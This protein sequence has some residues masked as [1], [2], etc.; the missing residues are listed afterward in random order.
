LLRTGGLV[1]PAEDRFQAGGSLAPNPLV[2][3]PGLVVSNPLAYH[4]GV[5]IEEDLV[6]EEEGAADGAF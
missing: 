1:Q 5:L 3:L 6:E 2:H 4:A